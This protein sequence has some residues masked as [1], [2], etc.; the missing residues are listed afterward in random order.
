MDT[1]K[2]GSCKNVNWCALVWMRL[3]TLS[4]NIADSATSIRSTALFFVHMLHEYT[5]RTPE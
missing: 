1:V 5:R 2:I 3:S 4:R